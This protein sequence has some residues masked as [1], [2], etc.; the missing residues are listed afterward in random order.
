MCV[1]QPFPI[2]ADPQLM[3]GI[4]VLEVDSTYLSFVRISSQ[5]VG[6][7]VWDDSGQGITE[8]LLQLS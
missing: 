8:G 2:P 3:V 5:M 1:L 6:R 7:V 4:S